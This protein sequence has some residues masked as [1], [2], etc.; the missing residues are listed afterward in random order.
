[1]LNGAPVKRCLRIADDIADDRHAPADP[2]E[3]A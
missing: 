2:R 3:L 1:M